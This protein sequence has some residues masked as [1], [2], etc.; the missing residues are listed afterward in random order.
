[1]IGFVI[2]GALL[3]MVRALVGVL[4]PQTYI[5]FIRLNAE[6][7]NNSKLSDKELLGR[8]RRLYI[9]AV[10]ISLIIVLMTLSMFQQS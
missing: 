10:I 7:S 2:G 8:A 6:M 5:R 3:V 9:Y 4:R 1:M